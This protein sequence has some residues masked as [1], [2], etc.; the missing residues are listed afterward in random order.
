MDRK[1]VYIRNGKDTFRHDAA[2]NIEVS[3]DYIDPRYTVNIPE[4]SKISDTGLLRLFTIKPNK[5]LN[6]PLFAV[7]WDEKEQAVDVDIVSK[8]ST[9][10]RLFKS[11]KDGYYGHHASRI[12]ESPR[13]YK[14]KIKIPDKKIFVGNTTFNISM[15]HA[16]NLGKIII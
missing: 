2:F 3:M 5:G 14:I 15:G 1:K 8:D 4:C 11:G 13:L 7:R 10:S 12:S 6:F 16:P 9:I